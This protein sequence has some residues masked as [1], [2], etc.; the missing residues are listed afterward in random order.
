MDLKI[1]LLSVKDSDESVFKQAGIVGPLAA[2]DPDPDVAADGAE[3]VIEN[4]EFKTARTANNA[5]IRAA[6]TAATNKNSQKKAVVDSY[7]VS[8][9][10]TDEKYANNPDHKKALGYKLGKKPAK[11]GKCAKI[12][13]GGTASQWDHDGFALL[14]WPS[15]GKMADYYVI[16]EATGDPAIEFNWYPANKPHSKESSAVVKPKKL[17]VPTWWRIT[18]YNSAGEGEAPSDPIRGKPIY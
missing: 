12:G 10:K 6:K 14:V 2:L 8:A 13:K 16:E 5:A 9:K 1:K 4:G 18:G 17:N 11:K 3:V 7:N 15:L